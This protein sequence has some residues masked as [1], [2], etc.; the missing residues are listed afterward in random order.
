MTRIIVAAILGVVLIPVGIYAL[1]AQHS[2]VLA[3][4]KVIEC[5]YAGRGQTCTGQWK[6]SSGTHFVGLVT[7]DYPNVGNVTPMRIHGDKA[8]TT[9]PLMPALLIGVGTVMLGGAGYAAR[10]RAVVTRQDKESH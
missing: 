10:R 5:H 4:V 8:Y 3:P 9:S 2:G 1:W 6:D 7:A